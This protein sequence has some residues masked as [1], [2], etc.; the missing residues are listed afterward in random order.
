MLGANGP[1]VDVTVLEAG[2][3]H[4]LGLALTAR[5]EE[6]PDLDAIG[7][8]LRAAEGFQLV[9]DEAPSIVDAAGRSEILVGE[10]AS[11]E[12]TRTLRIWATMDNLTGGT[13]ANVLRIL[14]SLPAAAPVH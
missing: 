11:G 7:A 14:D 3:F 1:P 10:L 13:A 8:S 9:E 12:D 5:L 2:V 4:G 6:A